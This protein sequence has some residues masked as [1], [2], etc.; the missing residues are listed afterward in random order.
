V[1]PKDDEL[2]AGNEAEGLV[3]DDEN[4]DENEAQAALGPSVPPGEP[5]AE[6]FT[7]DPN[8]AT[9]IQP[10]TQDDADAL[11]GQKE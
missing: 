9:G 8:P 4:Q 3:A 6:G 7:P 10:L 5:E 11:D 2:N 1:A